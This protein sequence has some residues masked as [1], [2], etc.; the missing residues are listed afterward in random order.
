M[1][2]LKIS[3][4]LILWMT[5]HSFSIAQT[6]AKYGF[7]LIEYLKT[8][9]PDSQVPLLVEGNSESLPS[10]IERYGGRVR[11]QVDH[12]FS[13]E[14]PAKHVPVFSSEAAVKLIEFSTTP[15]RTLS[16]T[17]LIHTNVDS[18]IQQALPLRT[19]YTGKGVLLGV[20][21]S[22]VELAHSDFQDSTGKTRVLYVWDQKQ[23]FDPTRQALQ[24]N[25]GVEWDSASINS[26]AST[27]DDRASEFGHGSNVTGAAASNGLA[28]GQF[29]QTYLCW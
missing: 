16:D 14:I 20:I 29:R 4:V 3:F 7:E 15:G 26:G 28:S 13:I 27:H 6:H 12:L 21:D 1:K 5:C 11:L 24:Y 23:A 10:I 18:I 19:K 2:N 9:T 25:Y 17:M 8:V 22:G